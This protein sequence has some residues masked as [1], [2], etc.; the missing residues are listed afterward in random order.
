MSVNEFE[1]NICTHIFLGGGMNL[2]EKQIKT[3]LFLL[4]EKIN[5]NSKDREEI[6]N[7]LDDDRQKTEAIKILLKNRHILLD[8]IHSKQKLL[9]NLDFTINKIKKG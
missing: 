4:L 9:D 6:F 1:M 8:E 2:I 3:D 7:G 5:L